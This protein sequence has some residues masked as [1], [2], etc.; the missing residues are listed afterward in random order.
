VAIKAAVV[1]QDEQEGGMRRILNFG[2]TLGHALEQ[3]SG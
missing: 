1:A 2:H 3:V